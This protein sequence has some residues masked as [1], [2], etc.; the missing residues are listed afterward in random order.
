M[1]TIFDY[2][3]IVDSHRPLDL[4]RY[5]CIKTYMYILPEISAHHLQLTYMGLHCFS[6]PSLHST[7]TTLIIPLITEYVHT[8]RYQFTA[9][10][11]N[12]GCDLLQHFYGRD[13]YYITECIVATYINVTQTAKGEISFKTI[14][15]KCLPIMLAI[16]SF[17]IL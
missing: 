5:V 2:L 8:T 9:Q 15:N 10:P 12:V 7:L 13:N 16:P 14:L 11:Y 17:C 1:M 4:N 3:D 6:V